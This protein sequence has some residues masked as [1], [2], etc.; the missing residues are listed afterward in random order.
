MIAL[1]QSQFAALADWLPPEQPGY[2]VGPHVLNTGFGRAWADRFPDPRALLVVTAGNYQF[3][4]APDAFIPDELAPLLKGFIDYPPSFEPLLRAACPDGIFW[5]RVVYQL[6]DLRPVPKPAGVEIRRLVAADAPALGD[7]GLETA[8][9]IKT[10]GEPIGAAASE[11][12]WGAFAEG[13]LAS[14]ACTFFMGT[15]YEDLGVATEPAY[16]GRGLSAACTHALCQDVLRR[17][18]RVSW[19]TSTDNPASIRVAEKV[20]F[21][22][23]RATRL[24]VVGIKLPE[25][26]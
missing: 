24:F 5:E 7:L 3:Y 19:N 2:L 26:E 14:V 20:G 16:R 13:R 10:W 9:V 1:P 15:H 17:G 12:A 18:K 25:A 23:V 11:A 4:G 22:F 6:A 8:W 21:R